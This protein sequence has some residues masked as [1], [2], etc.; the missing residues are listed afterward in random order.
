MSRRLL[1]GVGASLAAADWVL[2]IVAYPSLPATIPMHFDLGGSPDRFGPK[3]L[4]WF[5]PGVATLVFGLLFAVQFGDRRYNFPF[6]IA[7]AA[8]SRAQE[9]ARLLL[10]QLCVLI[11]A[12][13]LALE[14]V[15]VGAAR[16]QHGYPQIAA[17]W[18]CVALLIAAIVMH[19]M[20][21]W[22]TCRDAP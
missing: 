22:R 5:L 20:T 19:V 10:A 21:L 7:P 1:N 13:M 6:R 9:L 2:A 16:S 12:M 17:V 8:R 14:N 11:P 15:T 4:F 18:F 3:V